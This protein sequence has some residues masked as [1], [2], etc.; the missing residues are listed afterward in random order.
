MVKHFPVSYAS[1]F[2]SNF[3]FY[4]KIRIH[5]FINYDIIN[6]WYFLGT[7]RLCAYQRDESQYYPCALNF[8]GLN[9]WSLYRC[10]GHSKFDEATQQCIVKIPI[11]DQFEKFT[12]VA[13]YQNGPFQRIANFFVEKPQQRREPAISSIPFSKVM[14]QC[15]IY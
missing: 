6:H 1:I 11:S 8:I 5:V 3:L 14:P 13:D 15:K 9:S 12:S 2:Q 4:R 10:P 7:P